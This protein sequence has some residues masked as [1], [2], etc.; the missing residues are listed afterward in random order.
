MTLT[1]KTQTVTVWG[2]QIRVRVR[3]GDP[4]IPPLVMCNGI[5]ARL[6]VLQALVDQ[7]DPRIGVIRFDVPGVGESP[8][9]RVPYNYQTLAAAVGRVLDRLDVDRFDVFGLSWG[10]GLA[11]Q[12]GFQNPRRCRRIVLACTGTGMLMVPGRL[13]VLSNMLSGRRHRDPE[14]ATTLA[15]VIYGG[16][17][18]THP[19]RAGRILGAHGRGSSR[20]G[21]RRQLIAGIGWTSLP[22]LPTI[23]QQTLLLFGDDDPII[24]V[25]NGRILERLLPNAELHV[26]RGG[27]LDLVV[28]ADQHAPVMS[29]FLLAD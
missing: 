19:E 18:R 8:D 27:H 6:E 14:W 16:S 24:P 17:M 11:Q 26:F 29:A 10:G 15:P 25:V 2:H 5:G 9:S 12:I 21:Y 7:L 20:Q 23:R 28:D 13:G 22:W 1:E 3:P 4:S